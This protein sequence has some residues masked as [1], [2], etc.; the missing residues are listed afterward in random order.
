[1]LEPYDF[2]RY[3]SSPEILAD[4]FLEYCFYGKPAVYPIDPF[5][6]LKE[7]DI[8]FV[9]RDFKMYEG[10]YLAPENSEDISIV[11]INKNRPIT[12]QRFTAA[13]EICHHI[14]DKDKKT[15]CPVSGN[16]DDIEKYADR[17]AAAFLMPENELR[18]QVSKY[19]KGGYIDFDS[20]LQ[21]ADYFAIS[22]EACVFK[23]AY[24]LNKI[25]GETGAKKLKN[26]IKKFQPSRKRMLLSQSN[27][28]IDLFKAIL[29]NSISTF[30]FNSNK[31]VWYKFKNNFVY[32]ENRLEGLNIDIQTVSEI[33]TD[34]RLNKQRSEFCKDE[35]NVAI[36]VAGHASMYDY[37]LCNKDE[38]ISV[39]KLLELN[40][41]LFQYAPY[42]EAGGRTRTS[43]NLVLGAKFET[44]DYKK[45]PNA[46]L[47]LD[48]D[49]KKIINNIHSV[50]MCDLIDEAVK[51]HHKITVIHPFADGNGRTSRVF[52]N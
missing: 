17:F 39:F 15:F 6:V 45:I 44:L 12:R 30:I 11:A 7:M 8:P 37:I 13:H 18:K 35:Y 24:K 9:F 22:F 3:F 5:M 34:L 31:A 26:R 47:E 52:L 25:E 1:M 41:M 46:L 16:K 50:S 21:V 19:E 28:D 33:V 32:N 23:I 42:P 48:R 14:K 40:G 4:K 43:N 51:I 10:V 27:I 2:S 36:E 20:I 29:D 49:I 38:N